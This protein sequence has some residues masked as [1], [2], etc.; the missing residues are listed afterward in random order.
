MTFYI[1]VTHNFRGAE[2]Y[3]TPAY[4]WSTEPHTARAFDTRDAASD[5]ASRVGYFDRRP[6]VREVITAD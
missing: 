4:T 6:T 1:V 2:V 5:A 3:L